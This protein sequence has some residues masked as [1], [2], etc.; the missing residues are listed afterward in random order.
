MFA[1]MAAV[2]TALF[3]GSPGLSAP[4][5][6]TAPEP[7]EQASPTSF[8][9]SFDFMV[10]E[11]DVTLL[12]SN[13][14]GGFEESRGGTASIYSTLGGKA[15]LEVARTG[16]VPRLAFRYRHSSEGRWV[17][18]VARSERTGVRLTRSGGG[19]RHGRAELRRADPVAEDR[20]VLRAETFSDIT[21]VSFRWDEATSGDLGKSWE[22][23]WVM[24]FSRGRAEPKYPVWL[25]PPPLG[26]GPMRCEEEQFRLLEVLVGKW[27]GEGH[28]LD[29]ASILER[30]AVLG[31]LEVAGGGRELLFLRRD[32]VEQQ[33]VMGVLDDGPGSELR[34]YSGSGR[35]QWFDLV[36]EEGE[37]AGWAV[38][39]DSPG[40]YEDAGTKLLHYRGERYLRF[41]RIEDQPQ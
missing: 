29:V 40:T 23:E 39:R 6:D 2:L 15:I 27:R 34:I 35:N 32:A 16:P 21:P 24:E 14:E 28:R 13:G 38:S 22:Y 33:W 26:E 30:C 10:G 11:W 31:M 12:R 36:D 18:W 41:E 5:A 4:D 3:I 8:V 19:F 9:S 37:P 25:N 1:R 17:E 7:R 20:V